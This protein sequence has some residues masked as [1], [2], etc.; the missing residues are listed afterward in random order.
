M[1]SLEESRKK[2][3]AIDKELVSLFEKRMNVVLDV[4]RY[5]KE[6][7]LPVFQGNREEEVLK[8]A[9]DNLDDKDYAKEAKEFLNSIMEI[10]RGLQKRKIES[11]DNN[12]E[13]DIKLDN[14]DLDAKVGFQGVPGAFSE[15]ALIKIFGEDSNRFSYEEFEDVFEAIENDE[16]KYG[17]LPIENSSTGAI[18]K[19]MDLLK[20]YDFHIL[21]EETIKINQHLM[22]IKGTK[23][24]DI[25]EV[26]SHAQG[27]EQSSEFLKQYDWKLIPFHNTATSAKF[28][29]DTGDKSKAA[30]AGIRSAKIYDLEIIEECIN[31]LKDN[32]TRFV[33]IGK[34]LVVPK[35]AD[36]VSVAFTVENKSGKLFNI[37]R[38]FAENNINMIKIESRPMKDAPWSYLFYVAFEGS[39]ESNE[40]KKAL[41][42]IKNSSEYFRLLGA[43]KNAIE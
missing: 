30:I 42:L 32:T 6:N 19:V 39:I 25:K 37:L 34:E 24:E 38:Y 36:K 14:I 29:K 22:G 12:M 27:I 20:K 3:D 43:Y 15:E 26:Y 11:Q 17:V 8:K 18:S 5:K 7:K 33:V 41:E 1:A 21:A 4:A 13:F 2:I 16:I 31:T 23:L 28:V 40:A 10:S 35:N 9:V